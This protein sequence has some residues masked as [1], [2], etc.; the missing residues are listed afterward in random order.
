[1]TTASSRPR[2]TPPWAVLSQGVSSAGSLALA[3]AVLIAGGTTGFGHFSIAFAFY[4]LTLNATRAVAGSPMILKSDAEVAV[5]RTYA[6]VVVA[7]ALSAGS[8]SGLLLLGLLVPLGVPL[9]MAAVFALGM[10]VLMLQDTCRYVFFADLEPRTS[11][12]LDATWTLA[13]LAM[14]AGLAAVRSTEA[15]AYV[16]AWLV[17]ALLSVAVAISRRRVRPAFGP[18]LASLSAERRVLGPLAIEM[19]ALGALDF[20]C[21]AC[22]QVTRGTHVVG[23]YREAL[24]FLSPFNILL[25]GAIL[26]VVPRAIVARSRDTVYTGRVLVT[27]LGIGAIA[28]LAVGVTCALPVV[29]DSSRFRVIA[30]SWGWLVGIVLLSAA[31]AGVFALLRVEKRLTSAMWVRVATV[32]I[33]AVAVS[34]GAT[35]AAARGALGGYTATLG[36]ELVMVLAAGMSTLQRGWQPRNAR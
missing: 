9:D 33:A 13:Q 28:A 2:L 18:A 24:L 14:F 27:F 3:V 5:R 7:R 4:S 6:G 16:I 34:V 19:G 22:I 23:Q 11:L 17:G 20:V 26:G 21:V 31:L 30:D 1:M 12:V 15:V 32:P 35:A 10:P 36:L 29:N 8:L 25:T